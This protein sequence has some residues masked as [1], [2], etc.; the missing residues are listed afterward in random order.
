MQFVLVDRILELNPGRRIV[1]IK[2]LTLGEE[3]LQDHFPGFPVLPGV[4]MLETMVQAGAWLIRVTEDYRH[5]IIALKSVKALRYG[6]FVSPG[7]QL[8]L[9][10]DV[11]SQKDGETTLQGKGTVG[12]TSVVSGRIVLE[13]YNLADQ[14]LGLKRKDYEII[15]ALR[16]QFSWL[17]S[18]NIRSATSSGETVST[19]QSVTFTRAG[20]AK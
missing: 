2:N 9:Q 7:E 1:A 18:G 5:S 8:V 12:P 13:G 15:A 14:D 20:A 3:Y 11:K 16:T 6:N 17:V 10:V 4:L 19:S